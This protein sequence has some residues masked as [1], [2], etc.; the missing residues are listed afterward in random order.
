[1]ELSRLTLSLI[2]DTVSLFH[3]PPPAARNIDLDHTS[4]CHGIPPPTVQGSLPVA[5]IQGDSNNHD[6]SL[7][8]D[9]GDSV[10]TT[11]QDLSDNAPLDGGHDPEYFVFLTIQDLRKSFLSIRD[12]LTPDKTRNALSSVWS[13]IHKFAQVERYRLVP[14]I[15][16]T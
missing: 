1:M 14:A 2:I 16:V 15:V 12:N 7:L 11:L 5:T 6:V 9:H 10:S 13:S 3:R 4:E 8:P